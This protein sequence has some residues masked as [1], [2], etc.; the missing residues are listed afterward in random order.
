[1]NVKEAADKIRPDF[2]LESMPPEDRHHVKFI[3]D[4]AAE[5]GVEHTPFNLHQVGQALDRA[6]IHPESNEY[7][8]MLYSRSHHA[9]EG[10]G[11]SVYE[12]RH[13]FV[14]AHVA[15]EDEAKKLG[16][17]WVEDISELPP[18]GEIPLHAEPKAVE[19]A[20]AVEHEEPPFETTH[21][22]FVGE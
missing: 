5:L 1:M 12:P 4:V 8:K 2:H 10:I 9:E 22:E 19:Y 21:E 6:D 13:D 14:W 18:R 17:G 15:N 20:P 7:P 3:E 11:A 16:S